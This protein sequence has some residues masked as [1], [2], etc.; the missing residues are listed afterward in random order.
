MSI[1]FTKYYVSFTFYDL[2]TPPYLV[3]T[4]KYLF[5]YIINTLLF[6]I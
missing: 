5:D 6:S 3:L 4:K 2:T 1:L